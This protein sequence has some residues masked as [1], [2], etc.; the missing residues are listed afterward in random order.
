MTDLVFTVH[1]FT[2]EY[3]SI[4]YTVHKYKVKV[5]NQNHKIKVDN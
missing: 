1:Q 4:L 2:E 5:D 3:N